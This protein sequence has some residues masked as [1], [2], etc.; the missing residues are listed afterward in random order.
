MDKVI[1]KRRTTHIPFAS[2]AVSVKEYNVRGL[3]NKRGALSRD[4]HI[5]NR[6]KHAYRFNRDGCGRVIL[7]TVAVIPLSNDTAATCQGALTNVTTNR[8]AAFAQSS[9]DTE[10]SAS[11]NLRGCCG[12]EPES[13]RIFTQHKATQGRKLLHR[14]VTEYSGSISDVSRTVTTVTIAT[15]DKQERKIAAVGMHQGLQWSLRSFQQENQRWFNEVLPACKKAM[16]IPSGV[17]YQLLTLC[18]QRIEL[19]KAR[20]KWMSTTF[21]HLASSIALLMV[22]L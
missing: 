19:L 12:C 3:R 5:D 13:L 14:P 8:L 22:G 1:I 10:F 21:Q 9:E 2:I 18:S 4:S 7:N 17:T 15:N 20:A 16:P 11:H 6:A